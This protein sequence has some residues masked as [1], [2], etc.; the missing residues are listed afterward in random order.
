MMAAVYHEIV[1]KGDEALLKGFVR[2]FEVGR[3]LKGGFWLAGDHPVDLGHLKD[4]GLRGHCVHAICGAAVRKSV[5]NAISS[6]TDCGF[7]ILSDKEIVR[8]WL[9][10]E[11]DTFSREAAASIKG[12]LK[13]LP[14][15]LRILAYEPTETVDKDARGVELYSPV[16]DYR[17]EGEGRIEGDFE[18]LLSVRAKL[19]A[20]EVAKAGKIHLETS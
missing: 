3:S 15:G 4:R 9:E 20:I 8:A 11:F 2:G 6:A 5:L 17:F 7:E 12:I 16:H 10:F 13:N 19:D 18:K 14:A 1:V